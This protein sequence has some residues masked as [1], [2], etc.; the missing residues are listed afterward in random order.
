M[1]TWQLYKL[2]RA[3]PDDMNVYVQ[4]PINDDEAIPWKTIVRLRRRLRRLRKYA[5]EDGPFT[6]DF[7]DG[8]GFTHVMGINLDFDRNSAVLT[9]DSMVVY[10]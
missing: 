4:S 7:G 2:C 9:I 5:D 8:G 10:D 1:T 6:I 3:L